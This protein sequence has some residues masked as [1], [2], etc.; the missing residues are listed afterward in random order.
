MKDKH[1]EDMVK[2]NPIKLATVLGI[3]SWC[4]CNTKVRVEA[5]EIKSFKSNV[6]QEGFGNKEKEEDGIAG[7][8][9]VM[10]EMEVGNSVIVGTVKAP[11]KVLKRLCLKFMVLLSTL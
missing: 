6:R 7:K 1:L 10:E 11:P 4:M 9:A 2:A 5:G 8:H 3:D